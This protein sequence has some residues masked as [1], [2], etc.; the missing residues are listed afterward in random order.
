MEIKK[1]PDVTSW[2]QIVQ[3]S[4][5]ATFSFTPLW[6]EII[7]QTYTSYRVATREFLFDDGTKAV[8]PFIQTRAT[9]LL[10]GAE[11]LKSSVFG[12]YGGIIAEKTLSPSQQNQIYHYLTNLKASISIDTNPFSHYTLPDGFQTRK[13]FTQVL[14]LKTE[15]AEPS[16]KLSRG[17]KSNLS[18]AKKKG[19][20]VKAATSEQEIATYFS[21][22]QDTIRRWETAAFHHFP[23]AFFF[24]ILQKAGQAVK[25]WLAQKEGMV[26]GGAVIFYHNRIAW[27]WHGAS[28]QQ[29]FNCYPNNLL[30][31]EIINDARK[32]NYHYYD[33][34][35]SGGQAGVVRFKQ[36]FGV[37][38]REFISGHRKHRWRR[39]SL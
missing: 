17:A 26:I 25:L 14:C 32:K 35:P 28:L 5:E 8:I 38:K 21:I 3:K 2:E 10:K 39:K 15:E 19:V 9:G 16:L 11:R 29:F 36:S 33:F 12:G 7:V 23:E 4:P 34:G 24:N 22:Y 18:Q 1:W 6:H 13:N 37:E 30:H 27:Y 31:L 20:T